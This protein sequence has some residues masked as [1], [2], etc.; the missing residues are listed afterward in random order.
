MEND[1]QNELV[2]PVP[3][4]GGRGGRF[5]FEMGEGGIGRGR[6]NGGRIGM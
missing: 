6:A 2:R 3:R 5:H 4:E 1:F